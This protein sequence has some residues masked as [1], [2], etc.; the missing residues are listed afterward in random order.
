MEGLVIIFGTG[1][2]IAVSIAWLEHRTRTKA[3][4]VLRTY[5]ERGEEPPASI[6]EAIAAVGSAPRPGPRRGAGC[7]PTRAD[8]MAYFAA[9]IVAALGSA[10]I[11]WW[12]ILRSGEPGALAIVAVFAAVLFAMSA[13]ARLVSVFSAP[14]PVLENDMSHVAANFVGVVGTVG[15]AW[16]RTP[17]DGEPGKIVIWTLIVGIFL[18]AM[19]ARSLVRVFTA[20]SGGRS[21]EER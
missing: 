9:W 18:A 1:I 3:L 5:A 14:K 4:D 17:H 12:W 6:V 2:V 16:W 10:G 20:P 7:V 21:R 8:H 19:L 11:A 15:I 13:A